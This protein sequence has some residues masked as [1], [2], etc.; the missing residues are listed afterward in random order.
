M[1]SIHLFG[2]YFSLHRFE[3]HIASVMGQIRTTHSFDGEKNLKKKKKK[4]ERTA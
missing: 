4:K 2:E 3:H 1:F